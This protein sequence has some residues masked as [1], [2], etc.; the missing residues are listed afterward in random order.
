VITTSRCM[1][2]LSLSG[3]SIA[4]ALGLALWEGYF[5]R[6]G[7]AS[8]GQL[9]R[10][11][12]GV[13]T[14]NRLGFHLAWLMGGYPDLPA[15]L[16]PVCVAGSQRSMHRWRG[17]DGVSDAVCGRPHGPRRGSCSLIRADSQRLTGIQQWVVLSEE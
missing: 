13:F 10:Q 5:F 2:P 11:P 7:H 12:I 4:L 6:G 3:L 14:P 17:W 1:F 9:G 8:M 15:D 16:D